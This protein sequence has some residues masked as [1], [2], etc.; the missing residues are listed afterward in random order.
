MRIR[1]NNARSGQMP[2]QFSLADR[3][4]LTPARIGATRLDDQ[5]AKGLSES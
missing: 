2:R 3:N 4:M 5:F 1:G